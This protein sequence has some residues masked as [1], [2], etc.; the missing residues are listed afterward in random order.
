MAA[1][2]LES[3]TRASAAILAATSGG[4]CANA[5]AAAK[6]QSVARTAM[7]KSERAL[8]D[9]A[10]PPNGWFF[11]R[12]KFR[13][14]PRERTLADRSDGFSHSYLDPSTLPD[15][16]VAVPAGEPAVDADELGAGERQDAE[17]PQARIGRQPLDHR[18][19][20][21]EPEP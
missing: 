12:G 21:R 5:G 14:G 16:T 11:C 2:A 18:Q 19:R 6:P 13:A 3:T 17:V 7:A 15:V 8:D 20:A 9:M 1:V 4:I 10:F